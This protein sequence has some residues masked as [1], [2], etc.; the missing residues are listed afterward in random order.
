MSK[1]K[2]L[3][4]GLGL[5]PKHYEFVLENKPKIDWFEVISE[6]FLIPGGNPLY[7]LSKIREDYPIVL[8]GVSMS[9]GGSD[10]LDWDYLKQLKQLAERIDPPWMSD[11]LCWTGINGTNLHD[12][13][14]LPYTEESLKHVVERIKQ[15]QDFLGRQF[16]MENVSS[17]VTYKESTMSEW[18]F[19]RR[20]AEE[21]DCHILLDVNNIYVSSFNHGFDPMDYLNAIPIDRVQQFHIAGHTNKGT[22]IIDTHDHEI[23]DEVWDLY[24]N[25]VERFGHV[26]TMIERD[27]NIPDMPELI[28]EL[29][30]VREIANVVLN[31]EEVVV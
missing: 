2:Y 15:V 19:L 25:A 30:R 26:S 8:H 4:F 29:D 13:M 7:Y 3:G 16:L 24:T 14:P 5:R 17:Y 12:L 11:H 23:V 20:V 21:A 22:H 31:T 9:I 18:D 10:P 1:G 27:D 28:V 6:N